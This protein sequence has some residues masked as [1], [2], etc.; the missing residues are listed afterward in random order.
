MEFR[1][2]FIHPKMLSSNAEFNSMSQAQKGRI[3]LYLG[4]FLEIGKFIKL[5]K[6][7][8]EL[9]KKFNVD[10]KKIPRGDISKVNTWP[11]FL[12]TLL[13]LAESSI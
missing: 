7:I 1:H 2:N 3:N 8:K 11:L 13:D 10:R 9:V 12:A 4:N 6:E 5:R